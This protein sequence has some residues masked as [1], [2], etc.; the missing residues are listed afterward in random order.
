MGARARISKRLAW[1]GERTLQRPWGAWKMVR[2]AVISL[3]RLGEGSSL[4]CQVGC[5][6]G[7]KFILLCMGLLQ[8]YH[9]ESLIPGKPG[10]LT[11]LSG[12][13][14]IILGQTFTDIFSSESINLF[15]HVHSLTPSFM[16][17]HWT[18]ISY[19]PLYSS[20]N[21]DGGKI[22]FHSSLG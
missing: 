3:W 1:W 9:W 20:C 16:P 19:S 10:Q 22:D 11:T 8:F 18:A 17:G 15:L 2:I 14:R 21:W 7:D 13:Y 4:G 6:W 12:N 5:I